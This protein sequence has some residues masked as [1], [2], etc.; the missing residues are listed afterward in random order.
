MLSTTCSSVQSRLAHSVDQR[1]RD[2]ADHAA[3]GGQRG[4]GQHAHQAVVAAAVDQLAAALA[5]PAAD[6]A[7]AA[8]K[9][10]VDAGREP[11]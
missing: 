3:A 7:A 10:L 2:D 4:V 5:D 1:L 9:R 8:A 11:Q 6:F